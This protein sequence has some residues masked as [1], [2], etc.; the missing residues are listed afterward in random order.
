[1]ERHQLAANR[2]VKMKGLVKGS[3]NWKCLPCALRKG[4]GDIGGERKRREKR[5]NKSQ[6]FGRRRRDEGEKKREMIW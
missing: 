3:W 6:Q 1:M 4:G 2:L 5:E